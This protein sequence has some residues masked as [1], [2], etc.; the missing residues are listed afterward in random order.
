MKNLILRICLALVCLAAFSP[1]AKAQFREEAFN[2]TYNDPSDTTSARD[3]VDKMWSFREFFR[4]VSHKDT[5]LRIGTM[6]AG[7][8]V[9]IG[10]EQIYNKQYWKLPIIYGGIGTTLGLGIHY[11]SKYKHSKKGYD[12]AMALDPNMEFELD[13]R[14]KDMAKYMFASAGFIYW[15]T[16]MDGV[17]NYKRDV[18]NQPGKATIYSILLPGLG[19]AYNGEYWKIPIYWGMM[20]GSYHFYA[21]N[22]KNYKRFKRIHNEATNPDGGYTGSIPAER[23]LYFRNVYRRYRDYSVVAIVGSYLLQVIDANVFAY[24]QDFEMNDEL[25][26]NVTPTVISPYNEY[27]PPHNE[28]AIA[29][30]TRSVP[31]MS[32]G[33]GAFGDNAIGIKVGLRF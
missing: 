18:K 12:I 21:L 9:F 3:S 19:Q 11:N 2:Q 30:P 4:G 29:S 33:M 7:S 5:T 23:A 31:P 16:L 8:T 25:T 22:S 28:Y 17:V 6:F 26:L 20:I 14:S 32:F 24:M 15:A 13:T 10:S 1:G 27:I